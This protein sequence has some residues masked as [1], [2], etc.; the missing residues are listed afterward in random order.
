[1]EASRS[2]PIQFTTCT[3]TTR[4]LVWTETKSGWSCGPVSVRWYSLEQ[5]GV[6]LHGKL[7]SRPQGYTTASDSMRVAGRHKAVRKLMEE[8]A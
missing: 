6:F 1:M 8:K 5:W 3:R 2:D 4:S 7:I